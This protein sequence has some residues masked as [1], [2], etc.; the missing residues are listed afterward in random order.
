MIR[1]LE[2]KIFSYNQQLA[3]AEQELASG[4]I[5]LNRYEVQKTDILKLIAEYQA[6]LEDKACKLQEK[7]QELEKMT[8]NI[9]RV[10]RVVQPLSRHESL[11]N[12]RYSGST[13]GLRSR[14]GLSPDDS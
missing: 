7:E 9:D 5:T 8:K 12:L 13:N 14:T 6:K 2:A 1:R 3:K 10:G 11:V 4:K